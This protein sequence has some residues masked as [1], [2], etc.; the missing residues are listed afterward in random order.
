MHGYVLRHIKDYPWKAQSHSTRFQA[1][2]HPASESGSGGGA[3]QKANT[4]N[5]NYVRGPEL[6]VLLPSN[7]CRLKHLAYF[8]CPTGVSFPVFLSRSTLIVFI[9]IHVGVYAFVISVFVALIPGDPTF[10]S[11]RQC[12][13]CLF[14]GWPQVHNLQPLRHVSQL[15]LGTAWNIH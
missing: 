15:G 4:D 10:H 6:T 5:S 7:L 2:L 11:N 8:I 14:A 3:K 12:F 1:A 9:C 13:L